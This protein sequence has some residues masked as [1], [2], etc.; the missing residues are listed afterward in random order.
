[1]IGWITKEPS[2]MGRVGRKRVG[3]KSVWLARIREV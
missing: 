1:M 2:N 3:H